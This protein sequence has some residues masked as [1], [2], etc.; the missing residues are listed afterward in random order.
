MLDKGMIQFPG[1]MEQAD[2]KFHHALQSSQKFKTYD[3][4]WNFPFTFLKACLIMGTKT[5]EK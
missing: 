3:S 5:M 1:R 2:S 4:F